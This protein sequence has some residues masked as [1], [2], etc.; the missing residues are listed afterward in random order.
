MRWALLRFDLTD[1]PVDQPIIRATL[2]LTVLDPSSQVGL[3]NL[4]EGP[5]TE[6]TTW[7]TAPQLGD[8]IAPLPGTVEG[9]QVEIDV[10]PAISGPGVVDFYL[11]LSSPDGLE[12]ASRQSASGGPELLITLGEPGATGAAEGTILVGAGDIA[13]CAS[14]GDEATAALLDQVVDRAAEAVV[15][16]AGDNAYEGGSEQSF[17]DCYDPSWGRHKDITRP[18]VGSR[19][20]RTA[21]ASGYFNYFGGAAGEESQGYYS[22]DLDGWHIAVLNSN[23][24]RVG[25]CEQDSSQGQWLQEDLR[26]NSAAC[27]LAYWQR[28]L[29]TSGNEGGNPEVLPLFEILYDADAEI[30]VNGNDHFYERFG[31]QDPNGV[32]DIEEGIRQFIVGTGG[33]SLDEIGT[34]AVNSEVRF[35]EAFGVLSLTL[36]D[37][38]YGWRFVPVAGSDFTDLGGGTCQ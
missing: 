8:P 16:T 11:T 15:F 9:A 35:N 18:A 21:G 34:P 3:V 31:L 24:N 19:D 32:S 10:T 38:G 37:G 26:G 23:C 4:V 25:G 6:A 36:V 7:L 14:E 13:S 5:W 12:L 30:V 27:T 33:R 22:Y 20:Y 17:I 2:R 29:F 1:I 28:P